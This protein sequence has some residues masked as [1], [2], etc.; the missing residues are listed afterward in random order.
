MGAGN[1]RDRVEI[2]QQSEADDDAG[3]RVLE[4]VHYDEVWADV[5]LPNGKALVASDR[6]NS[7]VSGSIR[8][9]FRKDIT[10]GMRVLWSS[11]IFDVKAVLPDTDK[12]QHVDLVVETGGNDG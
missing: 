11:M 9:R 2:Q 7:L 12:R 3:Q 4:W 1:Y 10:A 8:I 6:E 5:L